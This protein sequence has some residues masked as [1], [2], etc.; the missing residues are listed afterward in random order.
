[1]PLF[2]KLIGKAIL[3]LTDVILES[4]EV[5]QPDE[6]GVVQAHGVKAM[7]VGAERVGQH[8][9]VAAVVL[10]TGRRIAIAETIELLGIDGEHHETMLHQSLDH[11]APRN[12][13]GHRNLSWQSQG[14]GAQP[15][16]EVRQT[17]GA[18]FDPALTDYRP[19]PIEETNPVSLGSPIDPHDEAKKIRRKI[20]QIVSFP[21]ACRV[22]HRPLYG[23]SEPMPRNRHKLPTGF[24]ARTTTPGC[25]SS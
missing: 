8:E 7:Q 2:S 10:A 3:F 24:S 25:F 16:D 9:G 11:G 5:A 13:D 22:E 15:I 1:M 18:V 23:H 17:A 12:F 14:L 19:L 20:L 21:S 6:G 4:R